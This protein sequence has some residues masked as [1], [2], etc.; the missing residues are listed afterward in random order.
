MSHSYEHA[1]ICFL[2]SSAQ[3]FSSLVG[4]LELRLVLLSGLGQGVRLGIWLGL[5]IELALG[6]WT[7][8]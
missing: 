6:S 8:G 2:E 4:K 1:A 5:G 3:A 7:H